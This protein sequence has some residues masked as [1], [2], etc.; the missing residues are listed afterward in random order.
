MLALE[1]ASSS[2]ARVLLA[3]RARVVMHASPLQSRPA[4]TAASCLAVVVAILVTSATRTAP[5]EGP[6][7][8]FAASAT[9]SWIE[10]LPCATAPKDALHNFTRPVGERARRAW[11]EPPL[12][13]LCCAPPPRA[14]RGDC[15]RAVIDDA[16]R[17]PDPLPQP[18]E[19]STAAPR[20]SRAVASEATRADAARRVAGGAAP[21]PPLP[22]PPLDEARYD[23]AALAE[24]VR[25]VLAS[26]FGVRRVAAVFPRLKTAYGWH[27]AHAAHP[28]SLDC[29]P[30]R[31]AAA[32]RWGEQPQ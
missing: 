28:A 5:P 29:D 15:F 22:P 31:P 25:H 20:A 26:R 10:W 11:R 18:A 17:L 12:R 1:G 16:I 27:S 3:H 13:Q 32:P 23:T 8:S 9:Y 2:L 4:A 14:R 21:P 19:A 6:V 7:R 30:H 24:Q